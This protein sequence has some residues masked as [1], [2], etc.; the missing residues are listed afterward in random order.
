[1]AERVVLGTRTADV[2]VNEQTCVGCGQC[3]QVCGSVLVL[4]GKKVQ[5]QPAAAG[6][7]CLGCGQCLAVCPTGSITVTGRGVEPEDVVPLPD[8]GERATADQLE[9]LL[10]SRR[11]IRKFAP[12]PVER[13]LLD[14]VLRMTATAPMGIPPSNVG[15]LLFDTREK[16]QE[17]SR[18]VV[19]TFQGFLKTVFSR[20]GLKLMGL[21][22]SRANKDAMRTFLRPLLVTIVEGRKQGKDY[23]LYDAPAALLFHY[24]PYS[25]QGDATIAATYAM[26]AAESLGLGTCMI[27]SVAPAVNRNKALK[28]KIGMPAENKASILLI[29]GY[30]AIRYRHAIRRR[31]ASTL[32]VP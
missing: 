22:M 25:D 9:N 5:V 32:L 11:S 30:P 14:R 1:M 3:A 12:R 17:L 10:L 2:H 19:R 20:T 27:G 29:L 7:G 26:I 21:F 23:L 13:D 8:P 6:F 15:V 18:E 4:Q 24:S 31:L 16:V 28:K